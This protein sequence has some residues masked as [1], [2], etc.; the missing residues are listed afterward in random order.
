MVDCK[1]CAHPYCVHAGKQ[2]GIVLDCANYKP[3]PKP[4]T[5]ADRIRAMSDEDLAEFL[6]EIVV[7]HHIKIAD[8]CRRC[9]LFGAKPCDTE[10]LMD[11]LQ[12]PVK[13]ET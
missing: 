6:N 8:E 4:Q 7:N 11:W 10:G 12:Q 2:R 5:N 13:E 9:P 1:I 3:S